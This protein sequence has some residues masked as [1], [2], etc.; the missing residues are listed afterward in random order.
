MAERVYCLYRVSTAK[1]VD[2]DAQNQADI[3]MQR[4]ACREF[5]DKMGWEII[6]EEQETGASGFKVSAADRDK[7]QLIKDHAKQGKFDIFQIFMFGR[8]R[9][10]AEELPFILED[11]FYRAS[12]YGA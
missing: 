11:L 7:I 12:E 1:Q 9:R 3:T 8:I 10:I 5:T 4:K 2:H 6:Y